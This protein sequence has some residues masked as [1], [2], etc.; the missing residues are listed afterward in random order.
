MNSEH[1][2]F[3]ITVTPVFWDKP[4]GMS[5]IIDGI[6][7]YNSLITEKTV[8]EF[9]HVLLFDSPHMLEI[10]RYGKDDS[11]TKQLDDGSW[12]DQVLELTQVKIDG[13]DIRNLIWAHSWNE[14]EYPEP[15][16]S[17][18]REQGNELE[19]RVYGETVFGHNG[20]WKFEFNSPFYK[21]IMNWMDGKI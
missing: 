2:K 12:K 14:P 20:N 11:Q 3:E 6:E 9:S 17:N 8:V 10:R 4:P 18:Q 15:W 1:I 13:V 16:A 21:H 5:V 7:K 19:E